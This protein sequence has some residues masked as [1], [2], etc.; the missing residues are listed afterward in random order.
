M[1][2]CKR[3]IAFNFDYPTA[4]A[5]A[6]L[7]ITAFNTCGADFGLANPSRSNKKFN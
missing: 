3:D 4:P 5:S 2:S 6:W 1:T 7:V